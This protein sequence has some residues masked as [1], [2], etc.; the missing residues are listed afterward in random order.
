MAGVLLFDS[1]GQPLGVH[2]GETLS[3][4]EGRIALEDSA[5]VL[6]DIEAYDDS[7][8]LAVERVGESDV[9]V[10]AV[11]LVEFERGI[12]YC[13]GLLLVRKLSG[14][15]HPGYVLAHFHYHIV[16]AGVVD[17][18]LL[19]ERT[20]VRDHPEHIT[21]HIGSFRNELARY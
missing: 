10:R 6:I 16:Q 18:D 5:A 11:H 17:I 3:G 2:L 21:F 13:L 7:L 12:N 15:F 14:D 20:H 19:N 8:N 1:G 9:I 4:A